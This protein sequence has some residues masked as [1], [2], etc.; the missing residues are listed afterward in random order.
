MTVDTGFSKYFYVS[1]EN[2]NDE[3]QLN[4]KTQ[5]VTAKFLQEPRLSYLKPVF[6]KISNLPGFGQILD[7]EDHYTCYFN[8]GSAVFSMDLNTE[9]GSL[10]NQLIEPF[11]QTLSLS[12]QIKYVLLLL[13]DFSPTY[14]KYENERIRI[15]GKDFQLILFF[16]PIAVLSA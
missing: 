6:Q 15:S 10:D 8:G 4:A 1:S 3:T 11:I 5:E 7:Q 9:P 16:P 14:Y 2:K 12:P 13:I